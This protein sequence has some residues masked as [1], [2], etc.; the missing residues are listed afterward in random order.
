MF[1]Q[2]AM[3]TDFL[4]FVECFIIYSLIG[5]VVES[6]YMSFCERRPVNR[7]F[8]KGPF[9]PIYG[10]GGAIGYLLMH[11][12]ENHVI[13]LYFT[14]VILATTFEF[15]VG[16]LMKRFLHKVWWD[17]NDKPFNYKGIICLESSIAWGFYAVI[18][19]RYLNRFVVGT[20]LMVPRR[21][22]MAV[23]AVIVTGYLIDFFYHLLAALDMTPA[24]CKD[25]IVENVREFRERW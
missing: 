23:C 1:S 3:G 2:T 6:V 24:E 16:M 12:L 11:S 19:V 13:G 9:C 22:G 21:I 7:G 8:A 5:W 17:Y 4:L 10:C 25:K 15:L 18:I 20:A 14:G